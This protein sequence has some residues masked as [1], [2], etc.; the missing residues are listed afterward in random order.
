MP[1]THVHAHVRD[2]AAAERFYVDWLGRRVARRRD[3]ITFLD[4]GAGFDLAPMDD[5]APQPVPAWFHLGIRRD[6]RASAV[7][8]HDRRAS[9]GVRIVEP[10]D[11]DALVS[12]RCADPEG[13]VAELHSKHA[14]P[15]GP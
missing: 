5:A 10:L 1:V 11:D 4:D 8:L 12:F 15:K 6:A 2:R 9:A 3:A 7:A 14:R 13:Y